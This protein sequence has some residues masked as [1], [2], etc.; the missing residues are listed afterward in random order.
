MIT[1]VEG[2]G[3]G[4]GKSY[5]VVTCVAATI[6]DG[7]TV[8]ASDEFVLRW[9]PFI[10]PM[11][12]ARPVGLD[13]LI[14]EA[15]LGKRGQT[16]PMGFR[17]YMNEK[18]GV[19]PQPSQFRHFSKE[20]ANRLHLVTLPGTE[21]NPVL[22]VVD[23]AHGALNARD[24]NKGGEEKRDFFHWLTQS[25]HDNNDV[26][27]I[28]QS[29]EN[30]DAQVRRLATYRVRTKNMAQISIPG[31]GKWPLKQFLWQRFGGNGKKLQ[32]WHLKWH[33]WRVFGAYVSK[34]CAGSHTR[35]LGEPVRRVEVAKVQSKRQQMI[36]IILC[37][38]GIGL[39]IYFTLKQWYSY[40][41][42]P[43]KTQTTENGKKPSVTPT[44]A[45][46]FP[47]RIGASEKP[48]TQYDLYT[49]E[50]RGIYGPNVI[51]TD[52]AFYEVGEMS[53]RGMVV[54]IRGRVVLVNQPDGRRGYVVCE[55][56]PM[57]ATGSVPIAALPTP[58]PGAASIRWEPVVSK[59]SD[60]ESARIKAELE[61]PLKN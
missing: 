28:T 1:L 42:H 47:F 5:Y 30:V 59:F 45:P 12:Y 10:G 13:G 39:G 20:D 35:L 26:I 15:I 34:A 40:G 22:V 43:E 48:Q 54:D 55:E 53:A 44:P 11:E 8:F 52:K 31:L 17:H 3:V 9:E 14:K 37:V 16:R 4:A 49:E 58:A 57:N 61:R 25:R 21:G 19:D 36:K 24:W 32:S 7:G 33:D 27:F 23:E 50:V 18:Y 56:R 2:E 60:S 6:A 41:K 29:L 38:L 46:S 51:R